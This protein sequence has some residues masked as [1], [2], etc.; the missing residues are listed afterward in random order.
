[1]TKG[2]ALAGAAG[3]SYC[4]LANRVAAVKKT[5]NR[6]VDDE[7]ESRRMALMDIIDSCVKDP[8]HIHP[9]HVTLQKRIREAS[10]QLT[11]Q[12]DAT[13]NNF[14]TVGRLEESW[15]VHFIC[16]RSAF[17]VGDVIEL[18]KGDG[19]SIWQ[20]LSYEIQIPL[21]YRL[22]KGMQVKDVCYSVMQ[23]RATE[24]G[25]RLH[26][27]KG[28]GYVG[29]RLN[30]RHGCYDLKFEEGK[31]SS[32]IHRAS[33]E[34][35]EIAAAERIITSDFLLCENWSDLTAHL[36]RTPFPP[37]RLSSFFSQ[38]EK[39]GPWKYAWPAGGKQKNFE[40]LVMRDFQA[41]EDTQKRKVGAVEE[42]QV[43]LTKL[44][45]DKQ[46][47]KMSV[48]RAKAVAQ[49]KQKKA[50]RTISLRATT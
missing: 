16:T 26:T 28:A 7:N 48:A 12:A 41:W 22:P 37:V 23:T 2:L 50:R 14:S 47:A 19:D 24:C 15:V 29:G 44:A 40:M 45:K 49:L 39:K 36:V 4:A 27:F 42:A 6:A 30:W 5:G 34:T 3:H 1:M 11:S 17:T 18:Q 43:Q 25:G 35:I 33:S 32:V 46:K 13:F 38:S 21:S 10:A 20:L 9:L 31:L 8:A